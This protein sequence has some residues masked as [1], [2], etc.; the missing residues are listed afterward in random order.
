MDDNLCMECDLNKLMDAA[1][2]QEIDYSFR[3]TPI[4]RFILIYFTRYAFVLARGIVGVLRR[5]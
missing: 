4:I 3:K 2:T 1:F 5:S